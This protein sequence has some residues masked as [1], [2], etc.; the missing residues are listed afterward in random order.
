MDR[1]QIL[2][3]TLTFDGGRN[4]TVYAPPD[5]PEA[6]VYVVDG[7]WHAE[8]LAGVL[9][10]CA[11]RPTMVVGVHG[12]DDDDGRLHEYVEGFGGERFAA[13][14]GFFVDEVQPWVG[15]HLG[16]TLPAERTAVWGASLGGE[17]ALAVGI[18][19]PEV[20]GTILC[21]SPGGGFTPAACDL[22]GSIPRTY[23]V[24]GR[25]EPWFLDNAKRWAD[26]LSGTGTDV[27]IEERNGEHG[28]AFW[29]DELPIM[30]A[31]AFRPEPG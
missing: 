27:V 12:V 23:L 11:E 8:R 16:V 7:G 9:D 22:S 5:P 21:A 10:T 18:R 14:E 4:V 28:D 13:F 1:A 29:Y 19:H 26:A 20:Y 15:S 2:T 30:V 24:A 31:W 17:F 6:I 3:E 25:Q